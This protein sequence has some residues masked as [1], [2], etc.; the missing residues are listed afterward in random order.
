VYY[1]EFFRKRP[2]VSWDDFNRV[3]RSAYKYWVELHPEDAPVLAVGRTWRLGPSAAQYMI[4]WKVPDFARL[5]EWTR[6]R[7]GDESSDA[8]VMQ[9]TLS[10]AEVDAGVYEDIGSE[11][12]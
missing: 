10:V 6:A 8:A 9:G 12:L 2:N 3:V 4:V 11:M 5:D 1:V 7:R